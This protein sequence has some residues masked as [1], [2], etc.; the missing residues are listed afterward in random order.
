MNKNVGFAKVNRKKSKQETMDVCITEDDVEGDDGEGDDVEGDD[1]KLKVEALKKE[2]VELQPPITVEQPI[3]PIPPNP[4]LE[5]NMADTL[6]PAGVQLSEGISPES[7]TLE[8]VMT[9]PITEPVMTSPDSGPVMTS[10]K[11]DIELTDMNQQPQP[12]P[13]VGPTT[14]TPDYE[15]KT[16]EEPFG[17]NKPPTK[18]KGDDAANSF[19]QLGGGAKKRKGKNKSLKTHARI[20]KYN[21]R[22]V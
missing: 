11:G 13:V 12:E 17:I 16:N 6:E 5:N 9:S 7:K 8:P 18:I 14:V 21:I 15:Q 4:E 22:F 2:D 20:K 19:D 10:Q 1:D 3:T